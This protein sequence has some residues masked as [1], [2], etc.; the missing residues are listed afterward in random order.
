LIRASGRAAGGL[1]EAFLLTVLQP[2]EKEIGGPGNGSALVE[3]E[4]SEQLRQ[5]LDAAALGREQEPPP[6]RRGLDPPG[7]TVSRI[8]PATHQAGDLEGPDQS[9]HGRRLDLLGAGELAE[10]ERAAIDH[11]GEGTE[12]RSAESEALVVAAGVTEQPECRSVEARRDVVERWI[13][14]GAC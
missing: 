13:G 2:A 12:P 11:D 14:R 3:P 6:L 7:S 8:R 10:A 9:G 1:G 4:A 5:M